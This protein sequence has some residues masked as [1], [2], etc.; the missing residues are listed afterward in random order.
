MTD[1]LSSSA[2]LLIDLQNDFI[3][4]L[5]AALPVPNAES[6]LPK[7]NLLTTFPFKAIIASRDWHP[8]HHSSFKEYG[9]KWSKHCIAGTKGAE[10]SPLLSLSPITHII[11]KAYNPDR[12]SYSCFFDE[13]YEG[14][15]LSE[16]LHGLKIKKIFFA[17]IALEYC[18]KESAK[19]AQKEGFETIILTDYCASFGTSEAEKSSLYTS[20]EEVE[21]LTLYKGIFSPPP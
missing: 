19:H 10:F 20:L 12:E 16:T 5:G 2:L 6:L 3:H 17:G 7:I 11:H 9:G 1:F 15:G 14:T 4:P 18:V 13:K 21:N 8:P